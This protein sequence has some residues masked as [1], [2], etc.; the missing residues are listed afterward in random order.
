MHRALLNA[1]RRVATVRSTVSTVEG[2]AFRLSDYSSKYLGHRIA[3][4]T[5]KL[6]IVN[7]DDTPALPIYR[8]TNAV[9]DVIDK[10]QDPNFDEQSLLKMYKTMT[11][12]NIMDR[13]L[14]DS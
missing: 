3:A 11:Q 13:I 6:E 9:G 14:Y 10:S 4:F 1:S 7:A 2:D 5:E 8:V 12:L